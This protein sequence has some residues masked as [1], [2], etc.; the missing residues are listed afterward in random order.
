MQLNIKKSLLDVHRYEQKIK[1]EVG[2]LRHS[3]NPKPFP[4][5][6]D[7]APINHVTSLPDLTRHTG[8][9]DRTYWV[10]TPHREDIAV[11]N[12][13]SDAIT[14]RLEYRNL[15]KTL[16]IE[17]QSKATVPGSHLDAER[18]HEGSLTTFRKVADTKSTLVTTDANKY[19]FEKLKFEYKI[20]QE[21]QKKKGQ[22]MYNNSTLEKRQIYE[23]QRNFREFQRAEN[24][25]D[26]FRQQKM[27]EEETKMFRDSIKLE[28]ELSP[29]EAISPLRPKDRPKL[30][31]NMSLD[32]LEQSILEQ[33]WALLPQV[34][35]DQSS[36]MSPGREGLSRLQ[37]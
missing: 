37:K 4:V 23:R 7:M 3:L 19:A 5:S 30:V 28:G 24:R 2:A 32:N 8:S 6:V 34:L 12:G 35:Q 26:L 14:G 18:Q 31:K 22:K 9:V 13:T 20:Q 1:N 16:S 27:M 15:D 10:E 33:N 25:K 17:A 29:M 11:T 21:K 36:S